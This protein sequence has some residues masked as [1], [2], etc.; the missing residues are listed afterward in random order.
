MTKGKLGKYSV[1]LASAVLAAML[2]TNASAVDDTYQQLKVLVQVLGLVR[3]NYV[4]EIATQ[5]LIYGAAKGIVGE[6]DDF[7]QF[8]EPDTNAKVKSDTE[9][10]FGGLGLKFMIVDKIPTVSTP[11]PKTP[12]Y[13]VG[14]L[15]GDKIVEIEGESTKGM[16]E[17]AIVKKLRGAPGTK[18]KI[19]L[20]REPGGEPFPEDK[21][22]EP[23]ADAKAAKPAEKKADTK[24]DDVTGGWLL[25]T[26]EITRELIVQEVVQHRMLE[27]NIGYVHILDF[28][29]HCTEETAKA[30]AELKKDGMKA[31]IIDLRYNP[32]GLLTSAV[33]ISKMFLDNNKMIVYTKGRRPE[34]YQEF[35]SDMSAPYSDLPVVV[36]INGGSASG[37]EIV[38]GALQDNKRAVLIGSRSFGKA[39]VQSIIPLADGS[40]LRLT[41]A[42]YYTPSGK[43]IHRDV[44]NNTGGITPDIEVNPDRATLVKIFRQYEKVYTPKGESSAVKKEDLVRDEA[45]ERAQEILKARDVF[46]ALA[47]GS[48]K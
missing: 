17:D 46:A 4:D 16:N 25:K 24:D 29:G 40:G 20:A 47:T 28:S 12:A 13:R 42:R 2:V 6:L 1:F 15:P 10:Q 23:K 44:K 45:L 18:V 37:S 30:L 48:A 43:S 26:V 22:A 9:G 33:D 36:L 21:P 35:R 32:G 38:A 14:I 19:T 3:D 7:S 11:L 41:V 5:K 39:S 34:N 8:M 31:V 27:N